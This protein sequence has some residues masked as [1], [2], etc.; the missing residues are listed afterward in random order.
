[1]WKNKVKFLNVLHD[2]WRQK[3]DNM[4][5]RKGMKE[6]E[7]KKQIENHKKLLTFY[8][9]LKNCCR[10]Y[11]HNFRKYFNYSQQFYI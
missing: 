2:A 7:K 1:M 4:R 9:T 10:D 5:S 11:L 6:E 8:Q 3:I